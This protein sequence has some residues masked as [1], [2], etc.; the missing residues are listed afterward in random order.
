MSYEIREREYQNRQ[1]EYQNRR[2]RRDERGLLG[3]LFFAIGV[4]ALLA[5]WAGPMWVIAGALVVMAGVLMVIA[6]ILTESKGGAR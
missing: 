3:V 4:T 6:S 2:R 1:R 5:W